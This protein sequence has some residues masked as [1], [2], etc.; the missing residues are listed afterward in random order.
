M[1]GADWVAMEA[2]FREEKEW[3]PVASGDLYDVCARRA[4][5]GELN[6]AGHQAKYVLMRQVRFPLDRVMM[7]GG[8][9]RSQAGRVS[10][11]PGGNP[12]WLYL[13][14][15]YRWDG[16]SG[17][18]IDT[19]S[20]RRGALFHD[21]FYTLIRQDTFC[22]GE[23]RGVIRCFAD[24]RFHSILC[25]DGMWRWRAAVWHFCVRGRGGAKAAGL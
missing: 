5:K 20:A 9:A 12:G 24:R 25:H 19:P 3:L 2:S 6:D 4:E 16:A 22:S 23:D 21:A 18:T 10:I 15:G 8:F 13:K 1:I 7:V 14:P 11:E 17:P